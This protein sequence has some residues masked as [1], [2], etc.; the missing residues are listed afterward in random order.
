MQSNYN[1]NYL[2]I[3][4][5]KRTTRDDCPYANQTINQLLTEMDGFNSSKEAVVVIGATNFS[6]NI[7][8]ALKRSGRLDIHVEVTLPDINGRQALFEHYLGKLTDVDEKIDLKLWASKAIKFSGA[9][10]ENVVNMAAIRA[11]AKGGYIFLFY[12]PAEGW[13]VLEI[14]F[15]FPF[16]VA[17]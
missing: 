5:G 13:P 10:I 14:S 8:E 7:D 2:H 12:L 16:S 3:P 11:A 9:D 15:L 17:F 4:T 1:H 6:E